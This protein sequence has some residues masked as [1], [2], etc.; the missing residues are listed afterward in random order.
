MM[1]NYVNAR[2]YRINMIRFT[3]LLLIFLTIIAPEVMLADSNNTTKLTPGDWQ[4]VAII[5]GSVKL[6]I[7]DFDDIPLGTI[8]EE[9]LFV[10]VSVRNNGKHEAP[11][12]KIRAYLVAVGDEN[13]IDTQIGS[14]IIDTHLGAGETRTYTKS[15]P[16]PAYLKE[17]EYKTRLVLDT[18]DYFEDSD[19]GNN[20]YLSN[21]SIIPG[22]LSGTEGEIPVYSPAEI[23]KPG[24][25]VL[26][27]DITDTK[28]MSVFQIK[29]SGVT[30]DGEGHTISG[31]STG[32]T[33]AISI[34]TGKAIEDFTVKDLTIEGYDVGLELYKVNKA[35]ITGCN[36]KNLKNMGLRLDQSQNN[37]ITKNN[38]QGNGMGIGVFQSRDNLIY[39]NFFK[40]QF[41]AV[42]NE[43][44]KN[45]WNVTPQPG[46][47]IIGGNVLAG[48]VWLDINGG[49]FSATGG[50]YT[51]DGIVDT[52]YAINSA[53]IDLYPLSSTSS[54]PVTPNQSG[55]TTP[56][57]S[58]VSE[59]QTVDGIA[60][61][62]E[63]ISD[64]TL[65]ASKASEPSENPIKGQG[66]DTEDT[67]VNIIGSKNNT[68]S[69]YADLSVKEI[70][71]PEE[72]C[73]G[74]EITI[75]VTLENSGGYDADSFLVL[76]YMSED[77]KIADND[78]SL[79]E[80]IIENLPSQKTETYDKQVIIP[81]STGIKKYYIGVIV[82][83][84]SELFE[85]KKENN[86]GIS[87]G[88]I[89]IQP[90]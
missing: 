84:G 69:Q 65:N 51:N 70:T 37:I 20:K 33:S 90:C 22:S 25:Y 10:T 15:W 40:N 5:N 50:D 31:E 8:P 1:E 27:R 86:N 60:N 88:R 80:S 41:N 49:G 18:S 58:T 3:I 71:I 62:T 11:G 30:F 28:K 39:N 38:F 75:A 73:P 12:Y 72:G 53:N 54:P 36:F 74:K 61:V 24:Y 78:V 87:T 63:V 59:N 68:T 2:N 52:P 26:K 48:N 32:F 9:S 66:N 4:D 43:E 79:G 6:D 77:K 35:N 45:N 46:A 83:P 29:S 17:G 64:H 7:D 85:D 19:T 44:Q 55:M 89:L 16:L 42:V 57:G 76:Y 14:D 34:N 21:Q 67:G 56:E 81:E 13:E 82:N 47:N 23:T